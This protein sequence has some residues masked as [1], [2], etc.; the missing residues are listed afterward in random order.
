M[1]EEQV[2]GLGFAELDPDG[3]VND[4]YCHHEW[5]RRGVGTQLQAA[6]EEEARRR[7]LGA[8]F[9][10]SSVTAHRFFLGQGFEIVE[11]KDNLICGSLARQFVMRKR[12]DPVAGSRQNLG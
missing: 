2:D 4:F 12:L 8:L 6:I 11:T 10:E 9:L 7:G 1:G 5:Q 3:H